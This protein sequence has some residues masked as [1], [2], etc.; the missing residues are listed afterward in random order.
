MRTSGK[1]DAELLKDA[2]PKK[3]PKTGLYDGDIEQV[4]EEVSKN[5]N[6]MFKCI[7]TFDDASNE[8]W[9]LT[10][11][12]TDTPKGGWLLRRCCAARGVLAKF[13]AGSVDQSDLPGPVRLK[14]GIE[15]GRR[16]WPDRLIV[17]DFAP[18]ASASS[19]VQ[20]LRAVG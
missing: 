14:I 12:L 6:E 8:K 10:V 17:E 20:N 13:E 2:R 4:T 1:S 15:K 3:F 18:P 7:V 11:Y 5:N 16:G 9:T 19:G